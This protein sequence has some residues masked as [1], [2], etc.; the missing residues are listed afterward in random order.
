MSKR[1]KRGPKLTPADYVSDLPFNGQ[2]VPPKRAPREP[3]TAQALQASTQAVLAPAAP[4][5][6]NVSASAHV[7][8]V[9]GRKASTRSR[10][11]ARVGP[12]ALRRRE[13]LS[14]FPAGLLAALPAPITLLCEACILGGTATAF[15]VTTSRDD[16]AQARRRQLVTLHGAEWA[17]VALAAARDRV[18]A[19]AFEDWC[20]AKQRDASW[21]LTPAVTVGCWVSTHDAH[22]PQGLTVGAVL[23]AC[24]ARLVDVSGAAVASADFWETTT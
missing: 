14:D 9:L 11:S 21:E 3:A 8:R 17:A 23:R 15:V 5:R 18:T 20:A 4:A 10:L 22:D 7:R 12:E 1:P 13:E 16:Y 19:V 6:P 24:G 2:A